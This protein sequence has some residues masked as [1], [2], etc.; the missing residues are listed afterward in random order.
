MTFSMI[1]SRYCRY[2][3]GYCIF[4]AVI[5]VIV[6]CCS[7]TAVARE[8]KAIVIVSSRIRPYLDTLEG[9][10]TRFN[11]DVDSFYVSENKKLAL[12][13]LKNGGYSIAVSVGPVATDMLWATDVGDMPRFSCMV[14]D[15]QNH[16]GKHQGCGIDL[17]IPVSA[18]LER[19]RRSMPG[20]RKIGILFDPDENSNT[21]EDA[22]S[23]AE[24]SGMQLIPMPVSSAGHI[25]PL[26][27]NTVSI[28]GM[29]ALLFI[30]DA[31]VTSSRMLIQHIIKAALLKHVAVIGYNSFFVRS[32]AVLA[33]VIDY[34]EVGRRA[35]DRVNDMLERGERCAI[36]PPPFHAIWNEKVWQR[37]SK[38]DEVFMPLEHGRGL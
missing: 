10:K 28:T 6:A 11:G 16:T 38:P 25:L 31:I 7:E 20:R 17:R 5:F 24:S 14:L 9:F 18:Q 15:L 12:H 34:R 22:S 23:Y 8:R 13:M 33:F 1:A 36:V 3:H 4:W 30:P 37:I 29:D 21:V 35:G 27:E 2:F 32:G 26:F 19:I